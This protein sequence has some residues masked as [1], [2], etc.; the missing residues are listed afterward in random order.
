MATSVS[1]KVLILGH[2]LVR[3]L[4]TDLR[5]ECVDRAVETFNVSGVDVRLYGVGGRT[6]QKL[7][8]YDLRQVAKCK[9]DIFLLEIGANDLTELAPEVVHVGSAIE[10]LVCLLHE[11]Y[12]VKIIGVSASIRRCVQSVTFNHNVNVLNQYLR[13]VLEP[14]D[15]AFFFDTG[16]RKPFGR[17]SFARWSSFELQGAIFVVQE[18]LG[19]NFNGKG[20]GGYMSC[21]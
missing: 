7:Q 18:L 14:L 19:S 8:D 5:R 6:V 13:V 2:S 1:T 4:A 21:M 9:S 12:C 16:F 10:D 3:R 17:S 20:Y 15:F 11:I